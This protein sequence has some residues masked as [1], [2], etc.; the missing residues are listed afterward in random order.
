MRDAG[1]KGFW[2]GYFAARAAPL[3]PVGPGV[4]VAAFYNFHPDMVR[5]AVPGCWDAV[6]PSTVARL[7][8]S[9]AAEA[10]A[11]LCS[12]GALAA[13]VSTLPLL[14]RLSDAC[15]GDGRIMTGAN[16]SLWPAI[17]PDID[18][19][20]RPVAEVWQATTTLR[21]HRGDGHV[22]ALVAHGLSGLEAHLMVT[23]TEGVAVETLR[24]N[25]G[26]SGA[27]WQEGAD[28]LARRGLLGDD[29]RATEAGHALR[30]E[31]EASTDRL[32]AAPWA[33]LTAAEV[34]SVITAMRQVAVQVQ[35]SGIYPYPNPMGL[36]A[37]ST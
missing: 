13:L 19:E 26:W 21:E 15:A 11:A 31:V 7:R 8:V 2:Q 3:G 9:A 27:T 6:T 5:A 33:A 4:V 20:L 1:L 29:G 12:A 24:D 30:R 14:R 28:Q 17:E 37:L 22:A 36:P 16:R 35:G 23:G 32:A 10:L 34:V 18:A 25:R